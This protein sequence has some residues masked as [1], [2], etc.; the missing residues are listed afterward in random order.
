MI[1]PVF[2]LDQT[3]K[4]IILD[5]L[6][7]YSKTQS[8]EIVVDKNLIIFNAK[9]YYLRLRLSND[10]LEDDELFLCTY[11]IDNGKRD[12]IFMNS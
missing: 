2:K 8:A 6:A 12:T 7:K 5:I 11:D 4:Y 10:L 3:E 9:P 1:T